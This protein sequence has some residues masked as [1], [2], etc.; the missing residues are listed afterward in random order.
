M[1]KSTW[2]IWTL[3]D[4]PLHHSFVQDLFTSCPVC[5]LPPKLIFM[6]SVSHYQ[7]IVYPAARSIFLKHCLHYIIPLP[8]EKKWPFIHLFNIHS[9]L[10]G[11]SPRKWRPNSRFNK[12]C[13]AFHILAPDYP[14]NFIYN[15]ST[16]ETPGIIL[17][18]L[19]VFWTEDMCFSPHNFCSCCS[20]FTCP[21]HSLRS[22]TNIISSFRPF[23]I[24]NL[25]CILSFSSGST[26][27][28]LPL[29]W[30]LSHFVLHYIN[31]VNSLF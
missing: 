1:S 6:P 15:Y 14:S 13:N 27:Y 30:D 9:A 21:S 3:I 24:L 23:I 10:A 31:W 12:T 5:F 11:W 16:T 18:V 29:M 17:T 25:L 26:Q 19:L 8:K 7:S 28:I 22:M 4:N 20:P 2:L